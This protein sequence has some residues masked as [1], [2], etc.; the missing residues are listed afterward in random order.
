LP[1]SDRQIV[2]STGDSGFQRDTTVIKLVL[3]KEQSG[4]AQSVIE[5][6][7]VVLVKGI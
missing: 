7:I 4:S 6:G 5:R 2:S 1:L 3:N